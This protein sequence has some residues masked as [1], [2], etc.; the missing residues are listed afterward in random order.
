MTVKD[1]ARRYGDMLDGADETPTLNDLCEAIDNIRKRS[2]QSGAD[3]Y[4]RGF[5][6][7]FASADDWIA[8]HEDAMRDHGWVKDSRER[9]DLLDEIAWLNSELHGAELD[10]DYMRKGSKARQAYLMG[11]ED[12][13]EEGEATGFMRGTDE[14]GKLEYKIKCLQSCLSD[15]EEHASMFMWENKQLIEERDKLRELLKA[16]C[17]YCVNGY[18][19]PGDGCPLLV[20]GRCTLPDR[21]CE[22]GVEV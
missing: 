1:W 20:D 8:Q 13:M 19:E 4:A 3:A 14:I 15:T 9:R 10:A 6:E 18:C 11:V 17:Y 21:M 5:D 2:R 22:F 12:G 7:G 16:T